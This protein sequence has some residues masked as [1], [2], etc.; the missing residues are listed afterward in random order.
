MKDLDSNFE[1]LRKLWAL[2]SEFPAP[3]FKNQPVIK[4]RIV[5]SIPNKESNLLK[6]FE[7]KTGSKYPQ[8]SK[9]KGWG[10]TKFSSSLMDVLPNKKQMDLYLNGVANNKSDSDSDR[11]DM[12]LTHRIGE[13]FPAPKKSLKIPNFSQLFHKRNFSSDGESPDETSNRRS[14]SHDKPTKNSSTPAPRVSSMPRT[15]PETQEEAPLAPRRGISQS[16][17]AIARTNIL[18]KQQPKVAPKSI[19]GTRRKSKPRIHKSPIKEERNRWKA[20]KS[21][22]VVKKKQNSDSESENPKKIESKESAPA[23]V[24]NYLDDYLA[25]HILSSDDDGKDH[26]VKT[27]PLGPSRI[28]S[29]RNRVLK[30]QSNKEPKE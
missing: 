1:N 25:I 2:N 19:K 24:K 27:Y 6:K 9:L 5:Q 23:P 4:P 18:T 29:V 17:T 21:Q 3:N 12:T 15:G 20:K 26:Y 11:N 14:R 7:S 10:D 22:V 16:M 13:S 8:D 28:Q 30:T